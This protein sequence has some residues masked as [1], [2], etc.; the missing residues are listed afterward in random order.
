MGWALEL[1]ASQT[2]KHGGREMASKYDAYWESRLREITQL[3]EEAYISGVSSDF[4]VS[5][6]RELGRRKSW[7]GLVEVSRKGVAKGEMVHARSLGEAVHRNGLVEPYGD[8]VFQMSISKNLMLRVK[9]LG[10]EESAAQ[11]SIS[12]ETYR[13]L[14]EIKH[15]VEA[16]L[17]E[18]MGLDEC[19]EIVLVLGIDS[20]L[21]DLLG[22]LDSAVLLSSL[23]QLG[24]RYPVQVYRYIA[25]TLKKGAASQER[26]AMRRRLG[27]HEPT[28]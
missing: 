4:D 15:V 12:E 27:F 2:H 16:V 25:D 13:R 8:A 5:D 9:R 14:K 11:I 18:K 3:L 6:I 10:F 28:G 24:A 19:A 1:R 26:E 22:S 23:Q 17:E 7:Y 20:I 21:E